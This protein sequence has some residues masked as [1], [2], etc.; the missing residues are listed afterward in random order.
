MSS[1]SPHAARSLFADSKRRLSDRVGVNVNN[2]ASVARQITR[3][4]KRINFFPKT[5]L[6][7]FLKVLNR[8][9]H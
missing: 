8:V 4:K 7:I 9:K 5:N 6:M 2:F 3:G 1:A